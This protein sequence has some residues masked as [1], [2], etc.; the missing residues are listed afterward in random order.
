MAQKRHGSDAGWREYEEKRPKGARRWIHIISPADG[1]YEMDGRHL[2][3][4]KQ[5]LLRSTEDE[6][7]VLAWLSRCLGM[8]QTHLVNS[9]ISSFALSHLPRLESAEDSPELLAAIERMHWLQR[10]RHTLPLDCGSD[11]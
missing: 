11:E 9:L 3:R 5:T 1:S 2:V 10:T 8:S 4:D 7:L 6:K